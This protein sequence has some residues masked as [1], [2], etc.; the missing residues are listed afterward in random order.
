MRRMQTKY[1]L[2][3]HRTRPQYATTTS[4]I[5]TTFDIIMYLDEDYNTFTVFSLIFAKK[6]EN[7]KLKTNM[8]RL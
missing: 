4:P 2:I 1:S 8:D 5:I 3:P 7:G 6:K